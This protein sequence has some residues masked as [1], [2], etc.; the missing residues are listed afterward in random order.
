MKHILVR[1][2]WDAESN[3]WVAESEDLPGLVTEAES[4]EA[5]RH[6]L[7]IIV[8]ELLELDGLPSDSFLLDV[9]ARSFEQVSPIAA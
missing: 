2:D 9:I 7:R 3:M 6:K 5:L 8:P 4:I 1:A